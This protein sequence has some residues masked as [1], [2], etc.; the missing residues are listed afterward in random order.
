MLRELLAHPGVEERFVAGGPVGFMAL[1]GGIEAGSWEVASTAARRTGSG[2]YGVVL[3]AGLWWHVPST[4]FS[5]RHSPRLRRFLE[6]IDIAFS[7]H[8]YGREEWGDTVLVGGSNRRVAASL[9]GALRRRGVAA[10]DDTD[11]IPAALRGVHPA[12]P[13]NLPPMGGVQV[14]LPPGLRDGPGA[15]QVIDALVATVAVEVRSLCARPPD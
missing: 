3:P 5:P 14:E 6:G 12:N 1:H 9:A 10:V 8:G 7:I 15:E 13:V 11:Q 2:L 4:E